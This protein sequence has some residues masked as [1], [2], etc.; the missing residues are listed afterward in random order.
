MKWTTPLL[1]TGLVAATLTLQ[2]C[3][4]LIVAGAGAGAVGGNAASSSLSIGT[5]VEDSTIKAKVVDVLNQYPALQNNSNV[6]IIVFNRIVLILGQVPSQALKTDIANDAAN[7]PRVRMVYNQLTVGPAV[8]FGRYAKDAWITTKIKGEMIGN[9]NPA[10]F[11]VVTEDGVVYLMGLT[12][13]AEGDVASRIASRTTGVKQVIEAYSYMH[14]EPK[15]KIES[16]D[17]E[18]PAS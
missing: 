9:V 11:K 2:A 10:D 7:V 5:Q 17:G 18:K 13:K 8:S 15:A 6:E 1:I 4:P 3:A 14:V 16:K 12:T